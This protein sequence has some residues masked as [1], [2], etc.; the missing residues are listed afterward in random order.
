MAKLRYLD[1]FRWSGRI[2][3]RIYK[4]G[5]YAGITCRNGCRCL[6]YLK[7]KISLQMAFE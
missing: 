2:I 1:S 6:L 5:F 3:G 7:N 4:S